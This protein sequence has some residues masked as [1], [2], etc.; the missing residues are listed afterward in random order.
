MESTNTRITLLHRLRD[1]RDDGSWAEFVEIYTPL[2]W[3][4]CRKR[5]LRS[6]DI[7]DIAQ[8]V[9]RSVWKA[10]SS[11]RY[12]PDKG[13]FRAWLFTVLRNT[14]IDHY[15]KAKRTPT[16]SR[17]TLWL[18]RLETPVDE[19]ALDWDHDYRLRILNWAMERVRPEFTQRNWAIFT[20]TSLN[21]RPPGEVAEQFDLRPNTVTVIKYRIMQRLR[22]VVQ[23]IDPERWEREMVA[24]GRGETPSSPAAEPVRKGNHG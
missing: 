24:A 22:Q 14:I 5:E 7:A 4:Y 13:H 1:R 3:A 2:V 21:E 9:F 17:Q 8:E 16:P 6:E 15:H 23:T 10:M 20:E 11:F 12:D 19:A 18:D